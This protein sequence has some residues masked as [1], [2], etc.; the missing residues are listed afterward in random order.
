MEY[1]NPIH[2]G[3]LIKEGTYIIVI[4]MDMAIA[5][6]FVIIILSVY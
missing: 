1:E 6:I 4:N 3:W 5:N 2:K